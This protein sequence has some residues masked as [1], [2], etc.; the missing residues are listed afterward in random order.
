MD[1]NRELR[2]DSL[3]ENTDVL[4][5]VMKRLMSVMNPIDIK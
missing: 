3:K 2:P 4:S 5:A 1:H